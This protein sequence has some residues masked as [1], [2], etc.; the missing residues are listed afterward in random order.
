[1]FR[2][3]ACTIWP[4]FSSSE[5]CLMR[6]VQREIGD[7]DQPVDAFFDLD[8]GAEIGEFAN[9]AFDDAADGVALVDRGPGI[10]LELLDAERDAAVL[11]GFTSSTTHST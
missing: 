9:A 1:M 11:D 5:G 6:L 7:V 10:G 4:F 3:T 8:E 2:M